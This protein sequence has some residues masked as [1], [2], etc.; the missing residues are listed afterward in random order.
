MV[1]GLLAGVGFAALH[2]TVTDSTG[3][4]LIRG[5][6]YGLLWWVAVPLS[7]LP[8][9]N[10]AGLLWG[11][12]DVRAI[13]P[14]L[15]ACILLGAAI[16]L[17][18]H[19]L[20]VLKSV[21]LSDVAVRTDSEGIGTQGLRALAAG[22]LSGFVG[23]LVFAGVMFQI[24]AFSSVAGL[25][26][27]ESAITGFFVHMGI[28]N[29]LGASYGLLFRRQSSDLGSGLG[30]GASY[31]FIWWMVG[32][33]TLFPVFQGA[34]PGWTSEAAATAFPSLIGH[35]AYGA[36]LGVTFYLLE[37]RYRPWWVPRDQAQ[38]TRVALRKKQILTSAPALWA[39][40]VVIS[41]TL[42]V[43]LGAG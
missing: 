22:L 38:A 36:S 31:G 17:F 24:G 34:T 23:G 21:L 35:L 37:A 16:A 19:W 13:F 15:P 12:S 39:L 11:V 41:L 30:W 3:V 43:L 2:P 8:S 14:T 29:M 33:L 7:V 18:Y 9:L 40:V 10:G 42:P 6:M 20:G 27:A 5:G 32:S 4:G 25:V 1:V 26:G 28:A